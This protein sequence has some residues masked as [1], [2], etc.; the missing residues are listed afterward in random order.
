MRIQLTNLRRLSSMKVNKIKSILEK[1]ALKIELREC[2][3]SPLGNI[4]TRHWKY[5]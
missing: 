2:L 4:N 3:I 1:N 5:N